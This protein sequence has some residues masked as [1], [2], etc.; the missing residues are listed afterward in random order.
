MQEQKSDSRSTVNH[1]PCSLAVRRE[2]THWCRSFPPHS[3][4]G[5]PLPPA[6]ANSAPSAPPARHPATQAAFTPTPRNANAPRL[7]TTGRSRPLLPEAV[8]PQSICSLELSQR[9]LPPGLP[10][11]FPGIG[12]FRWARRDAGA[13]IQHPGRRQTRRVDRQGGL[14]DPPTRPPSWTGSSPPGRSLRPPHQAPIV[15]PTH[16]K[17]AN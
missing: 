9:A 8:A 13:Q 1:R 12:G 6:L 2:H 3:R 11:D 16:L 17:L 4:L 5:D 15:R 7:L 14:T 10:R